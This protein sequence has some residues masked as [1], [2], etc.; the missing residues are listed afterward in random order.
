MDGRVIATSQFSNLLTYADIS[1]NQDVIYGETNA[2]VD[3]ERRLYAAGFAQYASN[4]YCVGGIDGSGDRIINVFKYDTYRETSNGALGAETIALSEY[5]EPISYAQCAISPDKLFVFAPVTNSGFTK[6][7]R[8]IDFDSTSHTILGNWNIESTG[9]IGATDS[10]FAPGF[11]YVNNKLF[12]VGGNVDQLGPSDGIY[13]YDLIGRSWNQVT[14]GIPISPVVY[15]PTG[16]MGNKLYFFDGGNSG[17]IVD[18]SNAYSVETITGSGTDKMVLTYDEYFDRMYMTNTPNI[19]Y[20]DNTNTV[21]DTG[22]SSGFVDGL[23]FNIVG[24]FNQRAVTLAGLKNG[25]PVSNIYSLDMGTGDTWHYTNLNI[26]I[27]PELSNCFFVGVQSPGDI[28]LIN[29]GVYYSSR[30]LPIID[31]KDSRSSNVLQVGIKQSNIYTSVELSS[32][33]NKGKFQN[34]YIN[35]VNSGGNILDVG[36]NGKDY[37][38]NF[39]QDGQGAGPVWA[40][41]C[42]NNDY[43][44]TANTYVSQLSFQNSSNILNN[45]MTFETTNPTGNTNPRADVVVSNVSTFNIDYSNVL[46]TNDILSFGVNGTVPI[47]DSNDCVTT[48]TSKFNPFT[49]GSFRGYPPIGIV[50]DTDNIPN[51]PWD[52][53]ESGGVITPPGSPGDISNV[54]VKDMYRQYLPSKIVR[55]GRVDNITFSYGASRYAPAVGGSADTYR[56]GVY[57]GDIA[58]VEMAE[59]KLSL[60]S[61]VAEGNQGDPA[62]FVEVYKYFSNVSDT[63][64]KDRGWYDEIILSFGS[65]TTLSGNKEYISIR[66]GFGTDAVSSNTTVTNATQV[67]DTVEVKF[68]N[69]DPINLSLTANV[70]YSS[71]AVD[72]KVYE[73]R[74]I[75][76]NTQT[77]NILSDPLGRSGNIVMYSTHNSGIIADKLDFGTRPVDGVTANFSQQLLATCLSSFRY[78]GITSNTQENVFRSVFPVRV[79]MNK[80]NS[81]GIYANNVGRSLIKKLEFSIGGQI[82]QET[83]DIWAIM[84]DQIFRTEDETESLKY[85]INNGA[86]YLPDSPTNFGPVDLYVPLD[87]FFCRN[88]RTSSTVL[89]D[90]KRSTKPYLP[91]CAFKDQDITISLTFYPQQYFSNTSETIDLSYLNTFLITEEAT[92]SDEERLYFMNT[93]QKFLIETNR[94]LPLQRFNLLTDTEQRYEGVVADFPV[95]SIHW[96]FRSEQ[97]ENENDSEYFLHRYN[98]STVVSTNESDRLYFE[99]LRRADFYIEGVPQIERFGDAKFYKY[100]QSLK[101]DLTS[102]NKNIY[103]YNFGMNPGKVDPEGSLNMSSFSS[104]KTFFSFFLNAKESSDA[105]EQVDTS[106]DV[107]IHAYAYGYQVL[108]IS[109][110]RASLSFA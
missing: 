55:S 49:S 76:L 11:E 61:F 58:G 30:N 6:I 28:P 70:I 5:I 18:T 100:Y 24:S 54:M 29:S 7:L 39:S 57:R 27:P 38:G 37:S 101:S 74:V 77:Y 93:P 62:N 2:Y 68:E 64:G 20:I 90:G 32:L 33:E 35:A 78:D 3:S 12:V 69:Y 97:F 83:D 72:R 46:Y 19:S 87:L 10:I 88:N 73:S 26:F 99:P 14:L 59:R 66:P 44:P 109:D 75:R 63:Y 45:Y 53:T 110:S 4:I 22:V 34:W 98:F 1:Y 106:R 50:Y 36:W 107:T 13:Y 52:F 65:N 15:T 16:V 71:S 95:K 67:T 102:V 103:S 85:L 79:G 89:S 84:K 9:F 82:I 80:Y 21:V 96:V 23:T 81:R 47:S 40:G 17:Y 91:L 43:V 86:D 92:I 108:E 31:I 41:D 105:I 42:I 25:A 56:Y 94:N 48:I 104:N 51:I 8:S 60:V